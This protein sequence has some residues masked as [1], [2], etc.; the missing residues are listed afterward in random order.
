MIRLDIEK[1]VESCLMQQP[2]FHTHAIAD[3]VPCIG[4][5]C[6]PKASSCS[7]PRML[8]SNRSKR[9]VTYLIARSLL[10]FSSSLHKTCSTNDPA[11]ASDLRFP[12]S[13]AYA[14]SSRVCFWPADESPGNGDG[15]SI[16]LGHVQRDVS[17]TAWEHSP[18]FVLTLP[19]PWI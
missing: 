8:L 10:P 6:I 12:S 3:K 5:F 19:A 17:L 13:R 15:A 1:T 11:S 9:A 7:A 2:Q 16:R 18:I 4:C 14:P